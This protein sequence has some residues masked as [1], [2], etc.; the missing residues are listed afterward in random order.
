MLQQA[1]W[2]SW[3]VEVDRELFKSRITPHTSKHN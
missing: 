3:T 2:K 1:G